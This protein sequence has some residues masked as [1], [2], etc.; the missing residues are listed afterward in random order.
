MITIK[1]DKEIEILREGGLIL[2]N[3][4]KQVGEL[5]KPGVSTSE[6]EDLACELIEKA[7]GRPAFKGYVID[8]T[9]DPYPTALCTSI[10]DEIVHAPAK[11]GRALESGDIIGI[12]VG[13][14]YPY[15]DKNQKGLYTDMARTFAVGKI[16][17]EAKKLMNT[18]RRSLELA[19]EKVRPGIKINDIGRVIQN[20]VEDKGFS[21]VRDLV[22][23]GVGYEVHE[24]PHIPHY[25][26]GPGYNT[27]LKEGMVIAIE[28]M[29]NI[30]SY[31]IK[32]AKDNMTFVTSD[33]SLSAHFEH[34]LAIV[35]GGCIII[36]S[37]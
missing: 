15:N 11:P 32:T 29:V 2:A 21:V 26:A 4:L 18:T 34:T 30:G 24:E 35:K 19:I 27:E 20:F 33:G 9:F 5:V 23:H 31:E 16:S 36:T 17:Q 37:L 22:G 10:N 3:I 12:D 1:T 14:E 13:M 7:G 28:P 6:L 25:Y 8:E